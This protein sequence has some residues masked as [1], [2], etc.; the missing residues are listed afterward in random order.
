[1]QGGAGGFFAG[2]QQAVADMERANS[3]FE[4]GRK[5][6][7][8]LASSITELA[9]SADADFNKIL[10]SFVNMLAQMAMQAAISSLFSGALGLLGGGGGGGAGGLISGLLGLLGFAEG[11]RPPVGVPSW[12]GEHGK[13]LFVPDQAGTIIP[14]DAFTR[15]AAMGGGAGPVVHIHQTVHV[16]EFVTTQQFAAG[17]SSVGRTAKEGAMQ[18]IIDARK[19]GGLKD[20]FK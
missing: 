17:L 4:M 1:A 10:A 8:E 6:T 2:M 7:N 5:F 15:G 16:G 12:V 9:T 20:V 18:G 3:A 13:E 14:T 11:G 19:R